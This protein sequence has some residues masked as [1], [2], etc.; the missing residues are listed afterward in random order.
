MIGVRSRRS[1]MMKRCCLAVTVVALLAGCAAPPKDRSAADA[2]VVGSADVRWI[3]S[4][5]VS[6]EA[7]RPGMGVSYGFNSSAGFASVF[8]Y[9]LGIEDWQPGISDPR[10]VDHFAETVLDIHHAERSGY[11]RDVRID[12]ARRLR[13]ADQEFISVE[14]GFE[15]RD[16]PVRSVLLLGV[17]NA[18]L[19]KFRITVF[20][21]AKLS[22]AVVVKRLVEQ[23]LADG[24]ARHSGATDEQP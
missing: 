9:S 7:E 14:A 12:K 10:L 22:T 6:H 2:P 5:P 4:P 15:F 17:R 16:E 23:V 19:L 20:D 11:Y 21:H 13:I 8:V 3:P 18:R 1:V 24:P